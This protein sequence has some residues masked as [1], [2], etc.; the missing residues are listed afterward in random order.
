MLRNPEL[1]ESVEQYIK[2]CMDYCVPTKLWKIHS[3]NKPWVTKYTKGILNYKKKNIIKK[4]ALKDVYRYIESRGIKL[5]VKML[6]HPKENNMKKVLHG[7]NLMSGYE[8]SHCKKTPIQYANDLNK[9]Y[10]RFNRHDISKCV[11]HVKSNAFINNSHFVC[12]EEQIRKE[13]KRL[14]PSKAAGPDGI[15]PKVLRMCV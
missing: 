10:N 2:L 14:R 1:D 3:S 5:N 4:I 12:T 8:S 11:D 15:S 7:V 9:F 6:K 13:L